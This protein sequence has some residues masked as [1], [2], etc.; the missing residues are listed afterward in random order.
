MISEGNENQ[1]KP[2][3]DSDDDT[4]DIHVT[5]FKNILSSTPRLV[6]T[7]YLDDEPMGNYASTRIWW[8]EE[9]LGF[10]LGEKG[11]WYDKDRDKA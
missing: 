11:I 3:V 2:F 10:S 6:S 9:I 8:W 1:T 5:I 4:V 7:T